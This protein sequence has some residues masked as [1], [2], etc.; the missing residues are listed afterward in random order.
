M[1]TR[2]GFL[3]ATSGTDPAPAAAT[4][5][6]AAGAGSVASGVEAALRVTTDA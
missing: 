6:A 1:I 2:S 4:R 5:P 3:T